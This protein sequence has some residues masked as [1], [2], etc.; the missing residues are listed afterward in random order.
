MKII[1]L[2]NKSAE[3]SEIKSNK[4]AIKLKEFNQHREGER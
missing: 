1:K 2:R 4:R 3:R